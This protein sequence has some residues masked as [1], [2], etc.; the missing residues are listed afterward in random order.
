MCIS[1]NVKKTTGNA[2]A[3]SVKMYEG[4][5]AGNKTNIDPFAK[6]NFAFDKKIF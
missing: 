3:S 1:W 4:W 5:L 6:A 2:N